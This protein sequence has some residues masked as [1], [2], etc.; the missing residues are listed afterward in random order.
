MRASAPSK[1][2]FSTSWPTNNEDIMDASASDSPL[3]TWKDALIILLLI[4]YAWFAYD[5]EDDSSRAKCPGAVS[6]VQ[7]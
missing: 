2:W 4:F 1:P 3:I 7:P 5:T 6:T